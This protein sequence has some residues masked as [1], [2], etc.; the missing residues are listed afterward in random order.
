[1]YKATLDCGELVAQTKDM[2]LKDSILDPL[3]EQCWELFKSYCDSFNM[4]IK[5]EENDSY[6]IDFDIAKTIQESIFRIFQEM[7]FK[8][9]DQH[10]GEI[11]K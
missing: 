8:L 9:K 4:K 3:E 6:M 2:V 10:T 5:Y 7:G 11:I 1:M